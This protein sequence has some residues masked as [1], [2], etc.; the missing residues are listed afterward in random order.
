MSWSILIPHG[1]T[2]EVSWIGLRPRLTVL[3]LGRLYV[4]KPKVSGRVRVS[5]IGSHGQ[6]V[7]FSRA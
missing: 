2:F 7:E 3:S 6:L 4:Y 1:A 5:P